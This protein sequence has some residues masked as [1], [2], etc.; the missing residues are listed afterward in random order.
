MSI[1]NNVRSLFCA[2]L[3]GS[4]SLSAQVDSSKS[5]VIIVPTSPSL[6]DGKKLEILPQ[7]S[8]TTKIDKPSFQFVTIDKFSQ[9]QKS[10]NVLDPVAHVSEKREVLPNGFANFG[11]GNLNAKNGSLLLANNNNPLNAYG[12]RY[13]HFSTDIPKS[14]KDFS[15]NDAGAFAKIF[16]GQDEFGASID[17]RRE[18]IRF[19][20]LP[21]SVEILD[22]NQISRL[23]EKVVVQ[24]YYQ[25]GQSNQ[26]GV[27][28]FMRFDGLFDRFYITGNQ[29]EN[30]FQLKGRARFEHEGFIKAGER[31]PLDISVE[32]HIDQVQ[33]SPTLKTDRYYGKVQGKEELTIPIGGKDLKLD[34]GIQIGIFAD[35]L[36]PETFITPQFYANYPLIKNKVTIMAGADGNYEKQTLHQLYT[37]N[38]F[39][40]DRIELRNKFTSL[41]LLAGLQANVAPGTVLSLEAATMQV[42]N[43]PL[44]V[45]SEDPFRR[46]NLVYDKGRHTYFKGQINF[47]LGDK[48]WFN[49]I[50]VYNDYK[51]ENQSNAW[52]YP[53]FEGK[54]RTHYILSKK[55][56]TRVD[57]LMLG[58]RYALDEN[59]NSVQLKPIIDANIGADFHF[60]KN[61]FA[62]FQLNNIANTMYQRW[63]QIPSY[64]MNG[65]LGVGYRF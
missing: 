55:L 3:F 25:N 65:T 56:F 22:R 27:K 64:G 61:F 29:F 33:V 48:F 35:S 60:G 40:Q 50:G 53:S 43:M 49:L 7:L 6:S 12:F 51:M 15:R 18:A 36:Q 62:F 14:F 21:D 34:V 31:Q 24:T 45:G 46:F 23:T 37:L 58:N 38:P 5:V 28:P 54:L 10:V 59:Q 39:L 32:A 13:N 47:N 17:F 44:F 30:S 11:Y 2:I 1:K 41:R 63:Y 16:K 52:L 8:R 57:L 26:I 4:F 9:T 19:F 20:S 42:E